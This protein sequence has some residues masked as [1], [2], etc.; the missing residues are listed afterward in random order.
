MRVH[1]VTHNTTHTTQHNTQHN[2]HTPGG[3]AE[4]EEQERHSGGWGCDE[5]HSAGRDGMGQ[6]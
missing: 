6:P 3:A 4:L 1:V 5:D 2:T